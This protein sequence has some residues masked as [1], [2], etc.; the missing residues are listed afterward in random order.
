[1]T[2]SRSA[3]T[4]RMDS[5]APTAP[6]EWPSADF[7]AYTG[8]C[9]TPATRIALASAGSPIGGAGA[10]ALTGSMALGSN[11]A[12]SIARSQECPRPRPVGGGAA[13]GAAAQG[14]VGGSRGGGAQ[15]GGDALGTR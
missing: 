9:S 1:M 2:P 12:E 14:G 8:A 3:S 10:V 7:G 4:V 6:I 13:Q 15:G 11:P 5:S